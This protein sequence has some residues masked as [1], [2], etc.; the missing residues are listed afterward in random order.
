[1]D[2]NLDLFFA[3]IADPTRRAVVERLV[4]GP[5]SVSELHA[6]HQMALPSFMKH[7][8]KL[9]EAGL[10]RSV[11]SGRVRTLHIEAAPLADAEAWLNRQRGQWS[12]RLDRLQA[13][14]EANE[15]VSQ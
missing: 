7:L 14:A 2:N 13:L 1:M 11:K 5:A 3:A 12:R 8:G 4:E 10:V 9:E 15:E 6:P